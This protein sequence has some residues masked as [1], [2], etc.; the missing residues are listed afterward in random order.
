MSDFSLPNKQS[1]SIFY[2][3]QT[4]FLPHLAYQHIIE[5]GPNYYSESYIQEE[6]TDILRN[7][8]LWVPLNEF[9]VHDKITPLE[10]KSEIKEKKEGIQDKQE[11]KKKTLRDLREN[12]LLDIPDF[13]EFSQKKQ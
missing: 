12:D 7:D 9:I 2:E 10:I 3:Q 11:N 8:Y 5:H 1:Q 13:E 4:L 6:K